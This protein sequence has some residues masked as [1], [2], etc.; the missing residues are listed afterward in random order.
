[1]AGALRQ[2]V[3]VAARTLR[4]NPGFAVVTF[5]TLALGIGATSAMFSIFNAVLLQPLPWRDPQGAV[6]IWSQWRAFDRTWLA[7]GEVLDYRQRM[8]TARSVAAWGEGQINVT[9][10]GEPERVGIGRVTANLFDALGAPPLIGRP[11]TAEEDVPSG[12]R[13]AV[14]SYGL[15]QRRFAGDRD[16]IGRGIML[17]GDGYRI[18]GVMPRGFMLPT[19]YDSTEPTEVWTP[20]QIDPKTADHG[21]HG[22]YGVARLKPG[23]TVAQATEELRSIARALTRE[24]FYPEAMKF[25]AFAVSLQDEVVGDVRPAVVAVF[26]AVG[27]LLLIACANVANLMLARAEARQREM[28][29]RT[30]LGASQGMVLRQLVTEGALI[31]LIAG[32]IGL[33]LSAIAVQ[34]LAWWN[35]AGIPRLAEARIDL[36]VAAFTFFIAVV[37][38]VLFSAAP[39]FRIFRTDLT[40]HL[41]E[42]NQN[43]T[44]GGGRQRYRAA[45]IVTET[46]LAVVLLVGAGLMLRT[47][48][49]LQRIDLGLDPSNVLTMRVS[50]PASGYEAPEAAVNFYRQ[51]VARVRALPGVKHAAAVRSLPLASTIGDFGLRIEGYMPP[52]GQNA[53]GDWQIATDGYLETLGERLVRGRSVHASDNENSMLVGLVNEHMAKVYW[54]GQDPIGRRFSVGSSP[55]RP[56]VTVVGIVR[57][58]RHNGV[59]GV[60]KEKFYIPHAQWHKS[61]GPMRSMYLVVRGEGGDVAGLVPSIRGEL[62]SI[63]PKIPLASVRTMDDVVDAALS[64]PRFTSALFTIFSALAVLL[65][66]VGIYGVL[67]YL[68][69]QRTREIGIRLAIGAS[70]AAV[71]REVLGRGLLMAA[72]GVAIGAGVAFLLGRAVSVLLYDVKPTDPLTFIAGGTVLLAVA[73]VAS[74]IPARRATTVDPVVALK[75]Q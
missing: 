55:T 21:S 71:S 3:R 37:V 34:W 63:D 28:A 42:G 69:T 64:A 56:W 9:G 20:L 11:F 51:L 41:K 57:D 31:A 23:A 45:L 73:S 30:A 32:A 14:I 15:W 48:D 70:P 54:P 13:V 66:A 27:F 10:E 39:A 43:A 52:P 8:T 74:Y 67:S 22:L 68:V 12:P 40:E 50:V 61:V 62:R 7:D 25:S 26:A 6:M 33:G 5:V 19:D 1:M 16:V 59:T 44:V 46:A 49:K 24:G 58:V 2:D 36:A 4:H 72:S 53:K 17:N 65:A 18:V 38:A 75:A 29:V 35:P 60:V 47:L